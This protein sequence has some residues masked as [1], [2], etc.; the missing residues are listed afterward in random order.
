[1]T[2][3]R[4]DGALSGALG[5]AFASLDR[6]VADERAPL[7]TPGLAT[8]GA[9]GAP[10]LRVVVLRAFDRGGPS[11]RVHT[12]RRSGKVGELA[13]DDRCS[14]LAYDPA[15]WTQ[16]RMEGRATLH[17]GDAL[18]GEAWAASR[19]SSLVAY[20]V[21]PAPGSPIARGGAYAMPDGDA[22]I[23]AGRANFC[24]IVVR[25][26]RLEWLHLAREG[27]RR[28]AFEFG[29]D[30]SLRHAAWLVP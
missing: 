17:A 2:A 18:A 12:D 8:R 5:E 29:E 11:L 16:L 23:E 3:G 27:H 30:G 4:G 13:G 19:A 28:A 9:D 25:V 15:S 26:R 1:M 7:R 22:A 24:V 6:A 20:G 10:R 21:E 14:L